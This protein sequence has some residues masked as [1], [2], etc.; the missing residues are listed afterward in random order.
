M[1]PLGGASFQRIHAGG[2]APMATSRAAMRSMCALPLPRGYFGSGRSASDQS[3]TLQSSSGR[4]L[5]SQGVPPAPVMVPTASIHCFPARRRALLAMST[6]CSP[7]HRMTVGRT[8]ARCAAS[9]ASRRS[10]NGYNG[11]SAVLAHLSLACMAVAQ[12]GGVA[13]KGNRE[14]AFMVTAV[15]RAIGANPATRPARVNQLVLM[16][17]MH[18]R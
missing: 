1:S 5:S 15:D 3:S 14:A 9:F 11:M 16:Q 8:L 12:P 13:L 4:R 6:L 18:L 2:S 10:S 7:S 17:F